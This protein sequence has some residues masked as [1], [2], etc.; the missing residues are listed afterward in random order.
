MF[1]NFAEILERVTCCVPTLVLWGDR[2]PYIPTEWARRFA[3]ARVIIL[4]DAGHWVAL[5]ATQ[6]LV[7]EAQRL[8][9]RGER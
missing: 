6:R 7:D 5:T 8:T 1:A 2:D 3:N 9:L 4:S